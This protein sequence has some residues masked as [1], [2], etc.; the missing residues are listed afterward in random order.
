VDR[1]LAAWKRLLEKFPASAWRTEAATQII[2]VLYAARDYAAC[3]PYCERAVKE[4]ADFAGTTE[5][6][7]VGAYCLGA[8]SRYDEADQWMDRYF[9][10]SDAHEAGWR[11]IIGAQRELRTGHVDQAISGIE[12]IDADFP[13][14]SRESRLDLTLRAA[15]M[16]TRENQAGRAREILTTA[17]AHS[18][19]HSEEDVET[20]LD[21]LE[22]AASGGETFPAMLRRLAADLSLPLM[23]R[24]LVRERQVGQLR[25]DD[26]A[27]EAETLLRE[28]LASEK[29]EYARF[30]V[31][32]LLADVL[33]EDRE[34]RAAASKVLSELLPGLKRPD[35]A[36]R[37]RAAIKPL[38]AP[39]EGAKD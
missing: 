7:Y 12:A 37:V 31:A 4:P 27:E 11:R 3:L 25:E 29:T 24:L 8:L 6:R 1:A 9:S 16:L 10:K 33:T 19:G 39:N 15:T 22:E 14:L 23:A 32:A 26:H 17:L 35:L 13:D 30:R 34:D 21:H 2:D 28:A 18:A 20:L 38:Q 36:N 5:A